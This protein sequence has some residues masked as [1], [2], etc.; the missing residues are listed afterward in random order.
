MRSIRLRSA[1]LLLAA[2]AVTAGCS[3]S[4]DAAAEPADSTPDTTTTSAP[5]SDSAW[6]TVFAESWIQGWSASTW[7]AK[8]RLLSM[9]S[10]IFSRAGSGF[11]CTSSEFA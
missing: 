5:A 7:A 1:A 4:S 9:P 8:K 3:G 6:P 2:A 11:D 10:T